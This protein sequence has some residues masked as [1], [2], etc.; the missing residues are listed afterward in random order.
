[1]AKDDFGNWDDVLKFSGFKLSEVRRSGSPCFKEIEKIIE[2]IRS[3]NNSSF[4]LNR[5]AL[6]QHS[7]LIKS[8]LEERYGSA[9]SGLSV[10][11]AALL[12]FENWDNALW[13]AGLDPSSIRLRSRPHLSNISITPHQKEDVKIGGERRLSSFVGWAP[14]N[15]EELMDER[16]TSNS[17][18]DTMDQ[19]DDDNRDTTQKIF[20]AIL[21]MHHYKDSKQMVKFISQDT[22][23]MEEQI[24]SLLSQFKSKYAN[25]KNTSLF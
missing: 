4:A 7:H 11:N 22:G 14:K 25:N 16:E 5:S 6:S 13:E 9:I 15:P 24:R 12:F 3:L 19:F 18:W 21:N 2:I 1:M 10:V 8:F 20:D 23:I 17:F